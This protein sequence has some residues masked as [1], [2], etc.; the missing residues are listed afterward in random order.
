MFEHW[1]AGFARV[2]GQEEKT[3]SS[4][5]GP[6]WLALWSP[7]G[8]RRLM[9]SASA[10]LVALLGLTA[11]SPAHAQER[12]IAIEH[13]DARIEVYS[14]AWIGVTETI[15]FRF[16]GAWNGVVRDIPVDYHT[17][18]GEPVHLRLR[19][20]AITDGSGSPLRHE[21][22][23]QQHCRSFK[24]W[25]PDAQDTDR[26]VVLR[27]QVKN[28][29]RFFERQD[30]LW[31][32]VTGDEWEMPIRGA[33]AVVVLPSSTTGIRALAVARKGSSTHEFTV[34]VDG[35]AVYFSP[36]QPL[37][38]GGLSVLVRWDKG[39]VHE[40]GVIEKSLGFLNANW[41]PVLVLVLVLVLVWALAIF[42]ALSLWR[43]YRQRRKNSHG[44]SR[45]GQ[46]WRKVYGRS[47]TLA[48]SGWRDR[49]GRCDRE[50]PSHDSGGTSHDFGGSA[51]DSASSS[52]TRLGGGGGR[53][54]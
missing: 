43:T 18:L 38:S 50:R 12:R 7:L 31:W 41:K 22:S 28:A 21:S 17:P 42:W 53:G 9:R 34:N 5:R 10:G 52:D 47:E 19:L 14:T 25:V 49:G 16:T 46:R 40:P 2:K 13:F 48:P 1:A 37:G 15:N 44:W 32:N 45:K 11:P 54:F 51:S 20:E 39:A 3:Q 23:R 35:K 4:C 36:L 24:I 29:L 8:E 33:S 30:E 6:G 27:Y 26:T